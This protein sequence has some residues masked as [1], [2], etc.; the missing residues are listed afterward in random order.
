MREITQIIIHCSA[1]KPNQDIGV[2]EIDAWHRKLGWSGIGYHFIICRNGETE[3]GRDLA[4]A[5]AHCRGQNKNSIGICLVGG[6]DEN[7]KSQNNFTPAQF[8]ALREL[9]QKLRA[10]FPNASVHGHNEFAAKDCPC[11]DVQGFLSEY[12]P[13][14]CRS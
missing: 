5:G 10:D 2:K 1:T 4:K 14:L 12:V 13:E 9:V 3:I 6:I 8:A 7:G 11:F